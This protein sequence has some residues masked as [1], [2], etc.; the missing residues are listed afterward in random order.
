M[1]TY[2]WASSP[3]PPPCLPEPCRPLGLPG[4]AAGASGRCPSVTTPGHGSRLHWHRLMAPTGEPS[5]V[6]TSFRT[7]AA[8]PAPADQPGFHVPSTCPA[9]AHSHDQHVLVSLARSVSQGVLKT[10]R[11]F[12]IFFLPLNASSTEPSKN[13]IL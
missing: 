7:P 11:L 8:E 5:R 12:P 3:P 9:A 2:P 1:H 6:S 4:R 13:F 10:P